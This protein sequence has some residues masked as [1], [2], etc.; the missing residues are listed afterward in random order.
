MAGKIKMKLQDRFKPTSFH[1]QWHITEQC[2]LHCQHCYYDPNLLKND[3][4]L[5]DLFKIL[6]KF[7]EQIKRWQLPKEAVR[8]SFTGGEPF[9]KKELF[10]LLQKC[11][12]NQNLFFYGILTNG[13]LLSQE[14]IKRI[15]DLKVSY[16]QVSLEGMEKINDSIRGKGT[17]NKIIKAITLLKKEKIPVSI[18]M[19]VSRAN[20]ADVPKVI[21]LAS[22][23]KVLVGI[24]R[25][26]P[27]GRG[28]EMGELFLSPNEVEGLY[29]DILEMKEKQWSQISLGCEDGI[30][31]QKPRY[32]SDG[33][34]AGYS[35]FTVLPNGNIYPC[36][37]LNIN[38]GNLLNQDFS[39]IYY[40]SK[41]LRELRNLNNI[42]EACH[43][44]PFFLECHG[45]AKCIAYAHFG[46]PFSPDPQCWR[47]FKKLP[48][49]D[50]KWKNINQKEERLVSRWIVNI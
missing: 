16:V 38:C 49:K 32:F 31:N 19:T 33:C 22:E 29:S 3:L 30:L 26:V 48:N 45:G 27:M 18:S 8:I 39:D 25:L 7:I 46:D 21:K 34:L 9:V 37:R 14:N 11:Y 24:R 44:C 36:R 15:K 5:S 50:L 13:T 10:E 35:S 12:E 23:L 4:E 41:I 43:G 6:N 2:N 1:L 17:F 47:L 28:K 42:N 20:I 40:N